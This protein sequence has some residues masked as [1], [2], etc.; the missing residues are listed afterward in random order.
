MTATRIGRFPT[1]FF[2]AIILSVALSPLR[3]HAAQISIHG[4]AGSSAFGQKVAVLYNGNIIVTDPDASAEKGAVYLYTSTGSLISTLSGDATGDHVGSGGVVVLGNGKFVVSS[5]DWANG[6]ATKAGAIT[7]VDGTHG[8]SASV[9]SDNSLVGSS[10][11]DQVGSAAFAKGTTL[12]KNGN[13][14]VVSPMWSNV[15]SQAVGAATWVNG[16]TGRTGPVSAANS[17][18]GTNA[19]DQVGSGGAVALSNG[20]YV[21]SSDTWN[22][23]RGAVTWGSG[24]GGLAGAVSDTNSMVGSQP[25][26][27]VGGGYDL[28]I[29]GFGQPP[30]YYRVGGV[31]ALT[32]G[33]YVVESPHWANGTSQSAGAATWAIGS[34]PSAGAVTATNSLVGSSSGDRVGDPVT[35]L[36]NGNYV[37]ASRGWANGANILAGA[38]TLGDGTKGVVGAV[39]SSNSLVGTHSNDYVG[40]TIIALSNGNYV[41]GS[42]EWNNQGS[43]SLGAVTWGNGQTGIIGSVSATNS[44]VGTTGGD[45]LG[46]Q[47]V[48]PLAN[49]NYVIA[50]SS[51]TNATA[52]AAGAVT[53]ANG[54]KP[55]IGVV[56]KT[57]SLVG[58]IPYD[59]V[60][61]D[62][63]T[64]L[65]N[66]NY[67]V[68]S[69]VWNGRQG[70]VTWADGSTGVSGD[71]SADNSLVGARS[72]DTL[73]GGGVT[74]L[75][76]GNYVI[77]SDG[78]NA[79]QS[80]GAASWIDATG[81]RTG[82]FA[83][84]SSNSLLNAN[85]GGGSYLQVLPTADGNYVVY[86]PA[87]SNI[88]SQAGA[89]SLGSGTKGLVGMVS[90]ANSVLGAVSDGGLSFSL[91][92]DATH[93]Q[94]VVG[95]PASNTV[96][97]LSIQASAPSIDIDGYLSGNWYDPQQA[98]Q[99][100]QLE[101]A[102]DNIMVAIWF[103]Y[104][105]DGSGQNW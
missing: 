51:W 17:L 21:V 93:G 54:S 18:I 52:T 2:F 7:W 87:A 32:N 38:A 44:L 6:T 49:G 5:P 63:V 55:L 66:G 65:P 19:G 53:W 99:G 104:T 84:S 47:G 101:M 9:S 75:T 48:F 100:F 89:A 20:N 94:L 78:T 60:G 90:A 45:F 71:V 81:P 76:N 95:E 30:T 13:V 31:S 56:T 25:D 10:A 50:S 88:A 15:A 39:S 77:A 62:G 92:Y 73:G 12:L 40:R 24:T 91:D 70:A 14:V 59:G 82:T 29:R 61:S 41:V 3:A 27:A 1:T 28:A 57:N 67:V 58:T 86:S 105:P 79:P 23:K 36:S 97:L 34:A 102:N 103:V 72:N 80:L 98:G 8:L 69:P 68:D 35:A 33:N 4:P 64:V 22:G 83:I 16:I 43:G 74:A 11:N 96:A 42:P 46:F 85:V 26:D 37:V